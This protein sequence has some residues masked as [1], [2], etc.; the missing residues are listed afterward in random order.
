MKEMKY[1]VV[2]SESDFEQMFIFS[3]DI[4]HNRFAEVLSYIKTGSER[5][6]KR[7]YREVVSAG[8]TDGITCYGRSE[9][10]LVD[11]RSNSDTLML[12]KI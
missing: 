8:F 3:K 2:R 4:D 1:V 5:D 9:T 7:E 10:L 6:W 12:N 11:S